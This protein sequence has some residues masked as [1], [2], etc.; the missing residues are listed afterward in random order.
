MITSSDQEVSLNWNFP[1]SSEL[2][3][4]NKREENDAFDKGL[5]CNGKK[6]DRPTSCSTEAIVCK[7]CTKSEKEACTNYQR[8]W[9]RTLWKVWWNPQATGMRTSCDYFN[10][11]EEKDVFDKGFLN[12]I[13]KTSLTNHQM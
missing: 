13:G 12:C 8:G 11:S 7:L 4:F 10:K 3:L 1:N 2:W 6:N 9:P 5:N